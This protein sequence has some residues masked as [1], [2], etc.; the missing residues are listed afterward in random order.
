MRP[1]LIQ[2]IARSYRRRVNETLKEYWD[3]KPRPKQTPMVWAGTKAQEA[4]AKNDLPNCTVVQD[5]IGA[6]S[7]MG[8][9]RE[10]DVLLAGRRVQFE[11]KTSDYK[12][13]RTRDQLA[14]QVFDLGLGTYGADALYRIFAN[15]GRIDVFTR[16]DAAKAVAAALGERGEFE[17]PQRSYSIPMDGSPKQETKTVEL[18]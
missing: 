1:E 7:T 4:W 5:A 6:V 17:T 15:E 10:T 8:N 14:A 11:V 9:P 18:V 16:E 13:A 12:N 2:T 3:V